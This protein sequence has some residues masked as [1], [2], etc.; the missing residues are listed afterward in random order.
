M[1]GPELGSEMGLGSG[2]RYLPVASSDRSADFLPCPRPAPHFL[3]LLRPV[4]PTLLL[5]LLTRP[6]YLVRVRAKGEGEGEGAG[7]GEGEGEGEL[8][9]AQPRGAD[10]VRI[11]GEQR[12][13]GLLG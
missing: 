8:H 9:L 11:V 4:L 10:G 5:T 13:E 3:P 12:D 2:W 6:A 7:E 1:V